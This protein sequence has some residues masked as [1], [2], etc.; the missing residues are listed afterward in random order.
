MEA[1]ST[2][3]FFGLFRSKRNFRH[4]VE[5][6]YFQ[7][8][9]INNTLFH[10]FL[11]LT[12]CCIVLSGGHRNESL[13]RSN[14]QSNDEQSDSSDEDME[15]IVYRHQEVLAW[16][17]TEDERVFHSLLQLLRSLNPHRSQHLDNALLFIMDS[18]QRHSCSILHLHE[19]FKTVFFGND[20]RIIMISLKSQ[21]L[22]GNF[23]LSLIPHTVQRLH[24]ERNLFTSISG[25][26]KLAGK[27]LNYLNLLANPL[28]LNLSSLLRVSPGSIGNPLKYLHVNAHQICLSLAGVKCNRSNPCSVRMKSLTE[29]VRE[30]AKQWINNSILKRISVGNHKKP[31]LIQ[32]QQA[33]CS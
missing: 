26:D 7:A 23:D 29:V 9:M 15:K 8:R 17:Q 21:H 33:T 20:S 16:D 1:I 12:I 19:R 32:R 10:F 2:K 30:P 4:H 25:L 18:I 22:K 5:S 24:L 31:M 27:N 13:A 11:F 28:D 3:N 6:I 14:N